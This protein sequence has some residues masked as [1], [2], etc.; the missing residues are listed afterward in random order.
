MKI[1]LTTIS[2]ICLAVI[3]IACSND[4]IKQNIFITDSWIECN[5]DLEKAKNI[6]GFSFPFEIT[7]FNVKAMKDMIEINYP[8]DRKRTVSIRKS[9]E[10][11]R[12]LNEHALFDISGDYN[13]Y[14]INEDIKLFD[15]VWF[16]IRRNHDKIYVANFSAE[17]GL[18]SI[19]C[20]YGLTIEEVKQIFKMIEKVETKDLYKKFP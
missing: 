7:N 17:T 1:F 15:S 14:P 13:K 4:K 3:L 18:Y 2:L 9:F 11:N 16:N 6:A 20:S 8:I 10:L 19:N 5:Q 12:K